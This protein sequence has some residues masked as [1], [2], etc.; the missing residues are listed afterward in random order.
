MSVTFGGCPHTYASVTY[1][2]SLD[3][4]GESHHIDWKHARGSFYRWAQILPVGMYCCQQI[5]GQALA[6]YLP[7]LLQELGFKG[8]NAQVA[9]LGPYGAAAVVSLVL[10]AVIWLTR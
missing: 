2:R 9:T 6:A 5:T 3:F 7:T 8:A 1:I 10:G 4:A